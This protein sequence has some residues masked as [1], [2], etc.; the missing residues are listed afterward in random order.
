MQID[1]Y[2]SKAWICCGVHAEKESGVILG[3]EC[4]GKDA[5]ELI[6]TL[7]IAVSLKA[8]VHQLAQ[9]DWY[10][11]TLAEIWTYPIEDLVEE[12]NQQNQ[13]K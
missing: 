5:G 12:I 6:H 11:P 1:S 2:G 7:S 13:K 10:H 3:A 9:A 4:V 8:S